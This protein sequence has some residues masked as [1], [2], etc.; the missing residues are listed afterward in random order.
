MSLMYCIAY[1]KLTQTRG[2]IGP[3]RLFGRDALYHPLIYAFLLGAILPVPI[4]LLARKRGKAPDSLWNFINTP[5]ILSSMTWIPPAGG[6]NFSSWA[7]VGFFSNFVLK[8]KRPDLWQRYNFVASAALD[9]SLA[10]A[11]VVGFFS[12]IYSGV[13]ANYG[14]EF[15][16]WLYKDSC[17]WK[18]CARLGALSHISAIIFH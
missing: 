11:V 18:G 14:L 7:L 12:L 4:Y 9:M 15:A 1:T 17:D 6:L 2:L 10:V 16:S 13:L 3:E 5:V 8:R